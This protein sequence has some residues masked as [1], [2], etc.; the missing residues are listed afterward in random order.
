[1]SN[2]VCFAVAESTELIIPLPSFRKYFDLKP[3]G[4]CQAFTPYQ[5]FS[6][7]RR[8]AGLQARAAAGFFRLVRRAIAVA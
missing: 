4:V 5:T 8:Q 2:L 7:A 1:M 3:A 6:T